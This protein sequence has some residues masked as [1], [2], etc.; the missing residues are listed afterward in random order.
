M[1]PARARS[2]C[3]PRG[4]QVSTTS[5][6]QGSVR[7]I[8]PGRPDDLISAHS[9]RRTCRDLVRREVFSDGGDTPTED[10]VGSVPGLRVGPAVMR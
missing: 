7:S 1:L 6:L 3:G 4:R 2:C 5:L 9:E 8:H 10:I